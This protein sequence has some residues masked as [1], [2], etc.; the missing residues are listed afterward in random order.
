[1]IGAATATTARAL[2][3]LASS[4]THKQSSAPTSVVVASSSS[5]R[6]FYRYCGVAAVVAAGTA[7]FLDDDKDGDHQEQHSRSGKLQYHHH[8]RHPHNHEKHPAYYWESTSSTKASRQK[9]F[10]PVRSL[11]L[12][13]SSLLISTLPTSYTS[14]EEHPPNAPLATSEKIPSPESSSSES[15]KATTTP[16]NQEEEDFLNT[17]GLYQHWLKEIKKQWAISS[18]SSI[19]WP[20]NIPQKDEIS[21]LEVDLQNYR[22]N[23]GNSRLC[24]DLEFRIA[25]YYLFRESDQEQQKKGFNLVKKLALDCHPD[26]LC[27]YGTIRYERMPLCVCVC[28][29]FLGVSLLFGFFTTS[30]MHSYYTPSHHHTILAMIWNHGGVAGMEAQPQLAVKVRYTTIAATVLAPTLPCVFN[31]CAT[32]TH[33]IPFAMTIYYILVLATSS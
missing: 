27:L 28:V 16:F 32:Y 30:D 19:R 18:P 7:T 1:M 20:T 2:P 11:L 15:S 9:A 6:G 5:T 24:Q 10:Y 29:C 26:G 21:A 25:S 13:P 17:I 4:G 23:E 33:T 12:V 14:C 31:V 3:R 22:K 8:H